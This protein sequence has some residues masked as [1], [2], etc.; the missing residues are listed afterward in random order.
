M[1]PDGPELLVSQGLLPQPPCPLLLLSCGIRLC[2]SRTS[3]WWLARC[4]RPHSLQCCW[5]HQSA[6]SNTCHA[7][8]SDTWRFCSITCKLESS[9]LPQVPWKNLP[10]PQPPLAQQGCLPPSESPV[11]CN[12]CVCRPC[13]RERP[14]LL[15]LSWVSRCSPA[16]LLHGL[17]SLLHH[18]AFGSACTLYVAS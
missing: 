5:C 7:C 8:A 18:L 4:S 14:N 13:C 16:Y 9:F 11:A 3:C 10:P 1:H 2:K 12:P 17:L 6:L 15:L